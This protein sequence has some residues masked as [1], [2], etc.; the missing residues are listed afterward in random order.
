MKAL[1]LGGTGL[2][3]SAC[4]E[5]ALAGDWDVSLLNRGGLKKFRVLPGEEMLQNDV[6]K[7]PEILQTLLRGQT[8]GTV[9]D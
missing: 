9:V 2:I 8:F 3:S 7:D 6:H 1:F 4:V 5:W